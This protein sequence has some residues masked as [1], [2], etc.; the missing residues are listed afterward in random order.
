MTHSQESILTR[1]KAGVLKGKRRVRL[2]ST[3][4]QSTSNEARFTTPTPA[5]LP[6]EYSRGVSLMVTLSLINPTQKDAT[7]VKRRD[8]VVSFEQLVHKIQ[9]RLRIQYRLCI[10]M[11]V[12]LTSL[13]ALTSAPLFINISA[14]LSPS[15]IRAAM[16]NGVSSA[17]RTSK[18]DKTL[19][20]VVPLSISL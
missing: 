19:L 2:R 11:K 17:Y 15:L 5:W 12:N 4:A 3:E 14:T 7:S 16:C 18:Q 20:K 8:L 9:A 13:A 10:N 1:K 6:K